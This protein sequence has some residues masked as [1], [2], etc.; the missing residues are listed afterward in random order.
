MMAWFALSSERGDE[1]LVLLRERAR[2]L[3]GEVEVAV[4]GIPHSHWHAEKARHLWMVG[5]E[6]DRRGMAGDVGDAD[7][8]RMVDDRAEKPASSRK[9]PDNGNLLWRHADID[10]LLEAAVLRDDPEGAVLGA[11]EL[12]RRFD[13]S[14]KHHRELD[15]LDDALVRLEQ[16]TESPLCVEHIACLPHEV[17]ERLV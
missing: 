3:I 7:R 9:V 1:L 11:N 12:D 14:L 17:V 13:D 5:G 15:V 4:D 8:V 2:L 6:A 10:E 16:S